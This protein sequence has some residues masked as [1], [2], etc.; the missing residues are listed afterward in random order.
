MPDL[1][2]RIKW[3][4]GEPLGLTIYQKPSFLD[5][6]REIRDE[7]YRYSLVDSKFITIWNGKQTIESPD[8]GE[9]SERCSESTST[10]LET[11]AV[12]FHDLA[13]GLLRCNRTVA[14]EAC[15]VFYRSNI[16]HFIGHEVW[17][18][19][20]LFLEMIGYKNRDYLRYLEIQ[21]HQPQQ[22]WQ[23]PDG[24]R[25]T[26]VYDWR[27]RKVVPSSGHLSMEPERFVEGIVDHVDPAIRAC[28]RILGKKRRTLTMTLNLD[29]HYLPGAQLYQDEQRSDNP[30]PFGMELPD[31]I[32]VFR[33]RYTTEPGTKSCVEV[34]WKGECIRER[35]T[36]QQQLVQKVG[37]EIIDI[38]E[39]E[40]PLDRYGPM[41]VTAFTLRRKELIV[42]SPA[43]D[44]QAGYHC[45]F[46]Y[47]AP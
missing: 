29:K 37:W 4:K 27:H 45:P 46:K 47:P 20:Y 36:E 30:Y 40:H 25:T 44:I 1:I 42:A 28:F 39:T 10:F 2:C 35:F 7:V 18:P 5:L 13:L 34:L 8:L 22:V 17:S 24:T 11:T 12:K 9:S 21:M 3:V 38:R 26:T 15:V 41:F 19:V 6:P 16:F 43:A 32:E 31:M 14:S 33:Q 23:H